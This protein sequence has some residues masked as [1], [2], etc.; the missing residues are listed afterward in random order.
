MAYVY[1]TSPSNQRIESFW[2]CLRKNFSQSWIDLFEDMER[3]ELLIPNKKHDIELAR[4]CFM[5]VFRQ[6]LHDEACRRNQ[7]RI[8]PSH[9]TEC[10]AGR[11]DELYFLPSDG[12]ADCKV[13]VSERYL[14]NTVEFVSSPSKC[15]NVDFASY[16]DHICVTKS[17]ESPASWK[18]S[19][20]LYL[21]LRNTVPDAS[22]H[23]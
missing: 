13:Q 20:R 23:L 10:P 16:L 19:L 11:P 5:D 1:G 7:H 17:W 12:F 6:A 21:N 2:S 14:Q 3:S 9:G 22:S 18:E 4:Y 15:A 8:R